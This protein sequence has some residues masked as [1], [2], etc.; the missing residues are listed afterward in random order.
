MPE[1]E[2]RSDQQPHAELQLS[3]EAATISHD[4]P[5]FLPRREAQERHRTTVK[6]LD[7]VEDASNEPHK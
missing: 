1:V 7:L 5:L 6:A 2:N 4:A 3:L